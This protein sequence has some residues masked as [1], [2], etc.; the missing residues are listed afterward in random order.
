MDCDIH[1]FEPDRSVFE[2]FR[3]FLKVVEE[4]AGREV[5]VVKVVVP[6]RTIPPNQ[7]EEEANTQLLPTQRFEMTR[8]RT[9][10]DTRVLYKIETARYGFELADLQTIEN[11]SRT[12]SETWASVKGEEDQVWKEASF[13]TTLKEQSMVNR[14]ASGVLASTDL[15]GTYG[16]YKQQV[17]SLMP[18]QRAPN[19]ANHL[20]LRIYKC[21]NFP[22]IVCWSLPPPY[23]AFTLPK[24]MSAILR[25]FLGQCTVTMMQR[26]QSAI[27][28]R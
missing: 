12:V 4:I 24:S 19:C 7:E 13:G 5:G 27:C 25:E 10:V 11:H 1:V 15:D 20:R 28:T 8:V 17:V 22:G 16:S 26:T 6:R 21:R 18:N 14:L 23:Q 9:S 3:S 2:D